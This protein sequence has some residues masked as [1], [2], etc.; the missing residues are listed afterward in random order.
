MASGGM[1]SGG[2]GG[3]WLHEGA[4]GAGW[5]KPVIGEADVLQVASSAHVLGQGRLGDAESVLR[6]EVG[7]GDANRHRLQIEDKSV[8]PGQPA[9]E[10]QVRLVLRG[11]ALQFDLEDGAWGYD[12]RHDAVLGVGSE[13]LEN[14]ERVV[15]V[16]VLGALLL[17]VHAGEHAAPADG[18][19]GHPW[20]V[21]RHEV[22]L[23]DHAVDQ[24]H[25]LD[26]HNNADEDQVQRVDDACEKR[27]VVGAARLTSHHERQVEA[28]AVRV[29]HGDL[30]LAQR[31]HKR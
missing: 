13:H 8:P 18:E 17:K 9:Q 24:R 29:I 16:L 19:V 15:H 22:V 1:R 25:R 27:Q 12:R 14:D 10:R 11:I 6:S 3:D 26:A 28:V 4:F 2:T 7:P 5:R 23:C 30:D 20:L 21:G 31:F